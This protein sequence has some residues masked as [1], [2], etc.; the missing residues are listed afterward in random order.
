MIRS[1][2][3]P[4]VLAIVLFAAG[5]VMYRVSFRLDEG[6]ATRLT[7]VADAH[8]FGPVGYRDPA[9]ALSPDG[10][11]IAFT[12]WNYDAQFWRTR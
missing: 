3:R 9:G 10:R 4:L 1:I 12:V 2:A 11:R 6:A 7:W 8:Q 5:V